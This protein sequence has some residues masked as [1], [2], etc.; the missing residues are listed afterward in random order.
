MPHDG[1]M[2][3]LGLL[4]EFKADG[5]PSPVALVPEWCNLSAKAAAA[6]PQ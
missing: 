5:G 4:L 2:A 1:G 6:V 3:A